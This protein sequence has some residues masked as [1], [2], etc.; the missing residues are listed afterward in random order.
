MVFPDEIKNFLQSLIKAKKNLHLYPDNNPIYIKTLDDLYNRLATLLDSQDDI[1]L[2]FKQFDIFYNSELVYHNDDKQESLALF[3]FKDGVREISFKKGIPKEE[4]EDFMKIISSDFERELV[5][6]D[7]VTLMW[8]KDFRFIQYVVDDTILLEDEGY[9]EMATKQV[10]ASASSEDQ[11]LKA[12]E[13]AFG[14]QKAPTINIVPLTNEDL[15]NIVEQIENEPLDKSDKMLIL[16]FEML[17]LADGQAE[18]EEI[19]DLIKSAIKYAV[20][21]GNLKALI[22]TLKS[23]KEITDKKLFPEKLLIILKGVEYFCNS[24]IIIKSFGNVL[25][26]GIEYDEDLIQ[27]L[28]QVMDSSAIPHFV[29]ILGQLNNISSRRT[30]I[31]ILSE[32]GK[33]DIKLLAR[34]MSDRRWYVVRNIIYVLRQIKDR[35]VMEFL[36]KALYHP[37]KRV[38]KEAI[39][40]VGELGDSSAVQN[41][42]DCLDDEDESVRINAVKAM[43]RIESPLSRK[44]LLEY[45]NNS[46]FN[47][48]SFTEKR[49]LLLALSRYRDREVVETLTRM[50]KKRSLF[51]K[52]KLTETKAAAAFALGVMKEKSAYNLLKRFVNDKNTLLRENAQMAIKRLG[53]V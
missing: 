12:Y 14:I 44:Y 32:L 36:T 18:F 34:G 5:D 26:Q 33:K 37:D 41:L 24:Q 42:R 31:R 15:R 28:S 8:E 35:T 13:E 29:N 30:I 11:I 38:K 43:G 23:I 45:I 4:F 27:E 53:D 50:L 6:D 9:E 10:I 49:E 17:Y 25:D 48:K 7:V 40:A 1:T 20:E 3:F 22:H 51:K 52:T 46:R 47:E 21:H 19:T 16:L 2:T 39:R